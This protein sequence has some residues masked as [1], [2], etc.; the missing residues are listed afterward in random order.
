MGEFDSRFD[1]MRRGDGASSA[2]SSRVRVSALGREGQLS[3]NLWLLAFMIA[4]ASLPYALPML[5]ERVSYAFARGRMRAEY[6]IASNHLSEDPLAELK[7]AYEAVSQK[8]APSVVHINVSRSGP[9]V[10]SDEM[11]QLFKMEPRRDEMRGQGSGVILDGNGYIVTNNHVIDS[12]DEVWVTLSDG[13]VV[14]AAV[15]GADPLTDLAVLKVDAPVELIPAEWGDSDALRVG[16]PVWA[17]GSPFG[18]QHTVTSGIVSATNRLGNTPYQDF[19]QTDAAVNPGNS[20][21]P[22]VDSQGRVVGVNTAIVGENYQGISF[23]VPSKIAQ[24]VFLKLRGEGEVA[25]GWLG[26][27]MGPVTD[28]LAAHLGLDEAAGAVVENVVDIGAQSPA[29]RAGV[30]IGDV[31]TLWDNRPVVSPADLSRF[32]AQSEIGA[33]VEMVVIRRGNELPLKVHVA[34]RPALSGAKK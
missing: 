8:I 30:R 9:P 12:A 26:V 1:D 23:A 4:C 15:V 33:I 3:R 16:A 27:Q 24:Q 6:E 31:I 20:G 28:E 2:G 7:L 11:T 34:K 18:L 5:V 21:G 10:F 14:A 22:L 13:Q 19:L 32:V 17:V 29:H 25:R